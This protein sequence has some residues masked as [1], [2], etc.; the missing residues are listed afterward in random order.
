MSNEVNQANQ[1]ADANVTKEGDKAPNT[2]AVNDGAMQKVQSD[3]LPSGP[4]DGSPNAAFSAMR[5]AGQ[6]KPNSAVES[7]LNNGFSIENR[8][9]GSGGKIAEGKPTDGSPIL[10]GQPVEAGKPVLP[11]EPVSQIA[12]GGMGKPA[13]TGTGKAEKLHEITG[14]GKDGMGG[15]E[16]PTQVQQVQ[17]GQD[18]HEGQ[19]LDFSVKQGAAEAGMAAGA[20]AA[21][22]A[23]EAV[24]QG[25]KELPL[26]G[27]QYQP[28]EH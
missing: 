1:N 5:D 6:G 10:K 17:E 22:G 28:I 7:M 3:S 14:S 9:T 13:L 19:R 12:D 24:A 16:R 11:G 15:S 27:H 25:V 23:V 18:G 4:G 20:A 21:R 2:S 26:K 8:A